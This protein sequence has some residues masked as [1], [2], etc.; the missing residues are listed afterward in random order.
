MADA[1]AQ[2]T[3]APSTN[4]AQLAKDATM[5][6]KNMGLDIPDDAQATLTSLGSN[7]FHSFLQ[8][9]RDDIS[10]PGPQKNDRPADRVLRAFSSAVESNPAEK[11]INS[12]VMSQFTYQT[13]ADIRAAHSHHFASPPSPQGRR[14]F[15]K[16]TLTRFSADIAHGTASRAEVTAVQEELKSEGFE[17]GKFGKD[18]NGVDGVAGKYTKAAMQKAGLAGLAPRSGNSLGHTLG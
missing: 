5:L 18:H 16:A 9:L 17:I 6:I 13:E 7:T 11:G 4:K 15:D 12:R 14:H 3:I 2:T 1:P 8:N 10:R